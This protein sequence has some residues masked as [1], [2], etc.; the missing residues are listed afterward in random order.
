MKNID[1]FCS[2]LV[3]EI[4]NCSAVTR[5][6]YECSTFYDIPNEMVL[7]K[8]LQ[9][10]KRQQFDK[11][12]LIDRYT[13]TTNKH[14]MIFRVEKLM[15]TKMCSVAFCIVAILPDISSAMCIVCAVPVHVRPSH[16]SRRITHKSTCYVWHNAFCLCHN[17]P[18]M[19][20][21]LRKFS[22]HM[23]SIGCARCT[24]NPENNII[25]V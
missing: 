10:K 5:L 19:L 21:S 13:N 22:I 15:L 14:M 9:E 23:E 17:S 4:V 1:C 8:N 2:L 12:C 18:R 16:P 3:I 11:G 24:H 6:A 25:P 20:P 7:R